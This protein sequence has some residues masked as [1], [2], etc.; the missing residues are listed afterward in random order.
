MAVSSSTSTPTT[1]RNFVGRQYGLDVVVDFGAQAD[2]I[3]AT[4]VTIN[5]P[6]NSMIVSGAVNVATVF[7]GTSPKLTVKDNAGS[8]VSFF[9][10]V[11]ADAVAVT[12]ALVA[13]AGA[14]YPFGTKLTIAVAGGTVTAGLAY[15]RISYVQLNRENEIY[16]VG[17]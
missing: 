13:G 6:P 2:D 17:G 8:P 16:S 1:P 5:L 15:V 12:A 3:L 11:A 4:G 14:V 9:G 10:N 7:G